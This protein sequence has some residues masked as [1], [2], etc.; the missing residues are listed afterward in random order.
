LQ[1][2]IVDASHHVSGS[3]LRILLNL[4]RRFLDA[5]LC[6]RTIG[7]YVDCRHHC[8]QNQGYAS[9]RALNHD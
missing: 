4:S 3:V 5:S 9:V 1:L 2:H 8:K 7:I 6:S